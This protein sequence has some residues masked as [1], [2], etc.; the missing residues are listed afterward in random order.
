LH[1]Q[2]LKTGEAKTRCISYFCKFEGQG[3]FKTVDYS[4]WFFP[5]VKR[6]FLPPEGSREVLK[7]A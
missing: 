3:E 1:A 6:L 5:V 4:K 7:V 2:G